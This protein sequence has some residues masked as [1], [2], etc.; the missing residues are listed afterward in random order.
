MYIRRIAFIMSAAL[1]G[2]GAASGPLVLAGADTPPPATAP[3]SGPTVTS[4]AGTFTVM[5]PGVGSLSFAV[6]PTTGAVSSLTVTPVDGSGFTASAPA[7]KSEG[8]QVLFTSATSTQ[9]LQVEVF[10]SPSGPM[11]TA[12]VDIP[13]PSTGDADDDTSPGGPPPTGSTGDHQSGQSRDHGEGDISS[14]G[15]ASTTS[16]PPS[17]PL[18]PPAGADH[19]GSGSESGTGG[20]GHSQTP[21]TGGG[22]GNSSGSDSGSGSSSSEGGSHSGPGGHGSLG[23][24]N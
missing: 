6:D 17:T 3:A 12:E 23:S 13:D 9:V 21:S 24:E 15:S 11:V 7:T 19:S 4:S 5:L 16:V 20:D 18:A 1:L 2:F 14:A 10:P 8:V 22:S